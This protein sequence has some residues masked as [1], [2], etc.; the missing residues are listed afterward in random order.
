MGETIIMLLGA[1]CLWSP[2]AGSLLKSGKT[3]TKTKGT[4]Y[5]YACMYGCVSYPVGL[6]L[7]PI[8]SVTAQSSFLQAKCSFNLLSSI[9]SGKLI[10]S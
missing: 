8:T 10:P 9:D 1:I 3:N 5:V 2:P 4:S 6:G 7:P